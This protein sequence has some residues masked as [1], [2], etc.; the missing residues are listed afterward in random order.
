MYPVLA[1]QFL[2]ITSPGAALASAGLGVV[3]HLFNTRI[4]KF[5]AIQQRGVNGVRRFA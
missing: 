5:D 3:P 2:G 4:D 1:V